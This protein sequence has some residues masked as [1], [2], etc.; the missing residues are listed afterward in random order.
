MQTLN[1]VRKR[2]VIYHKLELCD[3]DSISRVEQTVKGCAILSK[4]ALDVMACEVN[5]LLT[6][7]AS[8]IIPLS[9][10]VPRK[11]TLHTAA[12][13]LSCVQQPAH[14]Y[15]SLFLGIVE[16]KEKQQTYIY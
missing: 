8:C 10:C 13:V 4:R 12:V 6:L 1:K 11:V 9:Y 3:T 16:L 2:V 5:R 14:F 15:G 7:T